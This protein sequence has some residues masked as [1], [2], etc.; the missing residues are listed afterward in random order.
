MN[1][2]ALFVVA[3]LFS[4]FAAFAQASSCNPGEAVGVDE[5]I[6]HYRESVCAQ[7][8]LDQAASLYQSAVQ[9]EA[10]G[11]SK[12]LCSGIHAAL[13]L[14][15]KYRSGSWRNSH[16]HLAEKIDTS[17]DE[18]L[19]RFETTTCPQ[20]PSLYR[21]LAKQGNPWAMFRLADSYARGT[22]LPQ[23]D[24]EALAWYQQAAEQGY[25]PAFVALGLMFSDGQ[26]FVPDY[27]V[28]YQWFTK[29]A[30]LGDM[31]AQYQLGTLLRKGLGVARDPGQAAEW[32]RKAAAQGHAGAESALS[33]MYR[34]GEVKKP[35]FGL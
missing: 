14:L 19:A 6:A 1:R 31:Q 24:G 32:Y 12:T 15:D 9:A 2:F 18:K 27:A 10:R 7:K 29:A 35:F 33:D 11:D 21:H 5:K 13:M 8:A 26:A 34:A 17:F 30:A 25:V 23:N 28:A 20:K 16:G 4:F 22:G 3:P